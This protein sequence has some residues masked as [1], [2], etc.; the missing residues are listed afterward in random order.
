MKL[1]NIFKII[2]LINYLFK[3]YIVEINPEL[4]L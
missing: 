4:Q 3:V 2:L 1:L